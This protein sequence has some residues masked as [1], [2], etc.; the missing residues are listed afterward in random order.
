[1]SAY[2]LG[3]FLFPPSAL[4][5]LFF[6][7]QAVPYLLDRSFHAPSDPF[8]ATDLTPP[9]P[10]A[11]L[12]TSRTQ[13]PGP[14]LWSTCMPRDEGGVQSTRL[15]GEERGGH[16]GRLRARAAAEPDKHLTPPLPSHR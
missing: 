5:P 11:L 1:V 15:R 9:D 16:G 7:Y 3:H 4:P 13:P 10:A 12:T 14:V 2:A 8:M 6:S